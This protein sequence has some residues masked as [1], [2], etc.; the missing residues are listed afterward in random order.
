[1][2]WEALQRPVVSAQQN[3]KQGELQHN[4][5]VFDLFDFFS[6]DQ[7]EIKTQIEERNFHNCKKYCLRLKLVC[8]Y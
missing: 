1:M 4:Y 5:I 7:K 2:C 3:T 8:C 6:Y